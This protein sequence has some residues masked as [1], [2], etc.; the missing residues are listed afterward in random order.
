[1]RNLYWLS[2]AQMERLRPYFRKDHGVPRV[3]N[4]RILSGIIS[5]AMICDDK[6]N[7]LSMAPEDPLQ[8]MEKVERYG[9]IRPNRDGI[10]GKGL[11]QQ[12]NFH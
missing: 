11:R 8:S 5:I 6:I 7:R 12:V 2:E 4:R 9:R 3:N 1:M 10:G